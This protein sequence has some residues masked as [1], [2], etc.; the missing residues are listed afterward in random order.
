MSK[1]GTDLENL[2]ENE[3]VFEDVK[4]NVHV[5]KYASSDLRHDP[6]LIELSNR[7]KN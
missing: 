2:P 7:I 6:K 4:L 5:H 1:D 3:V